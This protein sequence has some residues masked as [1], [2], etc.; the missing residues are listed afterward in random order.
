[1]RIVMSELDQMFEA[2]SDTALPPLVRFCK[3]RKI[4]GDKIEVEVYRPDAGGGRTDLVV[5]RSE[6]GREQE[7]KQVEWDDGV[8]AG[9]VEIGI[10]ATNLQQEGE[11]FALSLRAAL[12]K[13][14]RRYG[15]GYMN[16]VLVDL[17]DA[18]DLCK[19]GEIAEVRKHVSVPPPPDRRG[20]NYQSC[21][22][23]LA[24]EISGRA[25]ELRDKL[26]YKPDEV[27]AVMTKALSIFLDER[28]SVSNRRR[29]GL[30]N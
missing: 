26:Q 25:V 29:F 18:S 8:N 1:V 13:I 5:H 20:R 28:F 23:A 6:Q 3:S 22:E 7:P 27:K 24:S 10:R 30:L 2:P 15:D 4:A 11:R 17:L 12:R 21:R 16:A 14:E 19:V 9:L